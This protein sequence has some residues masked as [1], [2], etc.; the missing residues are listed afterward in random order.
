LI[1]KWKQKYS[2]QNHTNHFRSCGLIKKWKQKYFEISIWED[3]YSCGLIKKWK[4]KYFSL[5]VNSAIYV[6]VWLKNGN[7]NIMFSTPISRFSLWFD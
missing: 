6:V 2:K 7:K 4:Q 5:S 1:K 3:G